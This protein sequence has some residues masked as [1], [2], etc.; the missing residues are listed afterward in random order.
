[1][2]LIIETYPSKLFLPVHT[3]SDG[4]ELL[5]SFTR[6]AGNPEAIYIDIGSD[7]E[8]TDSSV[9]QFLDDYFPELLDQA[10]N[11]DCEIISFFN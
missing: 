9:V 4:M 6:T 1:M 7:R 5:A 11:L 10:M 2:S 8:S 3:T